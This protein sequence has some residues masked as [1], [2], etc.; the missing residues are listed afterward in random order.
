MKLFSMMLLR[1]AEDGSGN[2]GGAGGDGGDNKGGAGSGDNAGGAGGAQPYFPQNFPDHLKGANDR[3]TIDKVYGAFS[4][5]REAMSKN[6]TVPK[7]SKDYQ[8]ALS[9]DA[10]KVLG[11]DLSKDR[12]AQIYRT[13]AHKH[14][15]TDKQATSLFREFMDEQISSGVITVLDPIK[16]AKTILGDA[17]IGRSDDEVKDLAGQRWNTLK[18]QLEGL[19]M[20]KKISPEMQDAAKQL[21]DT[22]HGVLFLE[23]LIK[24]TGE[25][26][27][28]TGGTAGG[29]GIT[30]A[31]LDARINDPRANP[32]H[33][34]FDQVFAD[35]TDRLGRAFYNGKAA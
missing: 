2:S 15:L 18:S 10:A 1:A 35:E 19:A 30:K 28:Q 12:T 27:I 22:A 13:L 24:M 31:D 34:K 16:E 9:D 32:H 4:G 11:A 23:T 20:S 6:G 8:L 3:E 21:M 7:E 14:G 25:H 29:G 33:P 5:A 17:A 26:G